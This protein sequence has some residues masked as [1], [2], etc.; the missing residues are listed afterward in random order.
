MISMPTGATPKILVLLATHNGANWLEEMLV[1]IRCQIGVDLT[2][3]VSDD[4]SSDTSVEILNAHAEVDPR[5]KILPFV[6]KFGAAGQN[7]FRL[8][9]AAEGFEFDA[10]AFADQ[11]DIWLPRKLIQ[12]Y[13]C[14]T[15]EGADGVSCD[16]AAFWPDGAIKHIVNS[17][18]VKRYDYYSQ[19]AGQGCTYLMSR[20]ACEL[21]WKVA[22]DVDLTHVTYHDWLMY[23]LVR[24]AGLHWVI[25][26]AVL[27]MY[28]QHGSNVIGSRGSFAGVKKRLMLVRS[29]WLREQMSLISGVVS[30][31]S[32]NPDAF[33]TSLAAPKPSW[34]RRFSLLKRAHQL[35]RD[36]AGAVMMTVFAILGWV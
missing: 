36:F 11:D 13:E 17:F 29:G 19:S 5:I 3:L 1:S 23:A 8:L 12:Q 20:R 9:K 15:K 14:M 10:L 27:V 24:G 25:M 6:G 32:P 7:F 34:R 33:A 26:N 16:V 18:P 4:A 31:L 2:I 30:R 28:R 35:R 21:F 22:P